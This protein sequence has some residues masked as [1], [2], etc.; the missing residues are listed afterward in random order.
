MV[1][2]PINFGSNKKDTKTASKNASGARMSDDDSNDPSHFSSFVK[3]SLQEEGILCNEDDEKMIDNAIE[4]TLLEV[5]KRSSNNPVSTQPSV[6]NR[7]RKLPTT[8]PMRA[9]FSDLAE[10]PPVA[11]KWG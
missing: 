8:S 5:D 10:P 6:Q 11:M 9:S 4:R 2:N 1:Q 3:H 7:L